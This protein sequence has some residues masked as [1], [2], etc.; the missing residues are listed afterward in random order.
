MNDYK[1]GKTSVNMLIFV[2]FIWYYYLFNK[3]G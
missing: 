1:Y 3:N 2:L